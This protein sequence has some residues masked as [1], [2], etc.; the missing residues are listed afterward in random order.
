MFGECSKIYHRKEGSIR[1]ICPPI[2]FKDIL[3]SNETSVRCYFL[4]FTFLSLP[5]GNI[6]V[7][8]PFNIPVS[9]LGSMRE[10]FH[11]FFVSLLIC[12]RKI[13]DHDFFQE[14]DIRSFDFDEPNFKIFPIFLIFHPNLI[15]MSRIIVDMF[16]YLYPNQMSRSSRRLSSSKP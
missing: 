16:L 1:C 6:F 3:L 13:D 12:F 2:K 4:T 14:S 15:S 10:Y 5:H 7:P 9:H 8:S 11:V